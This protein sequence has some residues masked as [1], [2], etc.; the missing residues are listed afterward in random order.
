MRLGPSSPRVQSQRAI[1]AV[2]TLARPGCQLGLEVL[3]VTT[4]YLAK[5][6]DLCVVRARKPSKH[7]SVMSAFTT[8]RGRSTQPICSS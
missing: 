5:A 1:V 4:G 7:R 2:V 8:L 6:G 3:E